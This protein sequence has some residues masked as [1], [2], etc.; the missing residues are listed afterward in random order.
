MIQVRPYRNGIVFALDGWSKMQRMFRAVKSEYQ[1]EVCLKG[2]TVHVKPV[3]HDKQ[4]GLVMRTLARCEAFLA[5]TFL[6]EKARNASLSWLMRHFRN[7]GWQIQKTDAAM[8][9]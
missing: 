1:L 4:E 9:A 7:R 5:Q 8:G 6:T 2:S 3:Y